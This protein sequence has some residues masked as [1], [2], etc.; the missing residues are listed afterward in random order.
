MIERSMQ[1][2]FLGLVV[3]SFLSLYRIIWGPHASDRILGTNVVLTNVILAII[4][5]A[6]MFHNYTYLDV[7]FVYVLSAFVGTIAV[8][9]S[10][11]KGKLS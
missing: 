7:A 4:I 8:M 3:L 2:V 10:L 1:A 9:K 11:G 5:L 6:H